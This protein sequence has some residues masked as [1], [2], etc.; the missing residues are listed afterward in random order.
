MQKHSIPRQIWRVIYPLLIYL[1]I[2]LFVTIVGGVVAGFFVIHDGVNPDEIA[3]AI[4][5]FLLDHGI[6][7]VLI[8]HLICLIVFALMW[9]KIRINLSKYDNAKLGLLTVALT[10][11]SCACVS[12][13]MTSLFDLTDIIQYFQSYEE[14]VEILGS[15]NL[16]VR[17]LPIVIA[18]PIGEELLHRGIVLNRLLSWMPKWVAVLVGSALFGLLHL[19]LLQG[20]Y[21]FVLGIAF[22]LLYVRYRNLWVPIFAHAAINLTSIAIVEILDTTGIEFNAW[23]LL[24]PSTLVAIVCVVLLIKLTKA[25][26]LIQEPEVEVEPTQIA[27]SEV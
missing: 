7:L 18:A 3:V 21:A 23:L 6:W 9:R 1:G 8:T 11:L 22:S 14:I 27:Y 19:N 25:A 4:E 2:S 15:G 5:S 10:I 26:V 16:L 17:S 24:I 20:L 12:N 13:I